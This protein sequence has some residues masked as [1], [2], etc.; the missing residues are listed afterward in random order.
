MI[1][2]KC[3]ALLFSVMVIM[4][5][6]ESTAFAFND[7]TVGSISGIVRGVEIHPAASF[8]SKNITVIRFQDGRVVTFFGITVG[9]IIKEGKCQSFEHSSDWN[10]LSVKKCDDTPMTGK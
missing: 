6:S 4:T 3:F 5:I 2:K 9:L 8:A 7:K 10:I 1:I